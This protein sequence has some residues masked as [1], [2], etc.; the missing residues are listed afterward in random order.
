MKTLQTRLEQINGQSIIELLMNNMP[1]LY[2]TIINTAI[3]H[4][5]IVFLLCMCMNS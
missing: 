1:M 4:A 5:M 2:K 3:Y